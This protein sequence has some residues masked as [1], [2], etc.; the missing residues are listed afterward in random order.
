MAASKKSAAPGTG[1]VAW[2]KDQRKPRIPMQ[3]QDK[4]GLES[5]LRPR[6]QYEAPLYRRANKLHGKA[7]LSTGGDS[8][9]GRAVA[10][11]FAREGADVAIVYLAEARSAADETQKGVEREGRQC[12]LVPGDVRHRGFCRRAADQTV[13]ALGKLDIL[14][15]NAA[16]QQ[17]QAGLEEITEEQ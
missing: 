17:H 6:P 12:Q 7:A 4:P 11:L 15:D 13:K 9:I 5:K 16:C 8:S 14:V 1:T 10:V 3:H 2:Q